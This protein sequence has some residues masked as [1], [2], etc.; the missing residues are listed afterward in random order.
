MERKWAVS[1]FN[2][3]GRA[4]VWVDSPVRDY[5]RSACGLDERKENLMGMQDARGMSNAVSRC[6]ICEKAS[7]RSN[8]R[9]NARHEVASR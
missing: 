9:I 8:T 2:R 7:L 5:A 6:R 4:H 1:M 3:A